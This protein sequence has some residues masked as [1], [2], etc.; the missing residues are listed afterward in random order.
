MINERINPQH[1]AKM[2]VS[3]V[4]ALLLTMSHACDENQNAVNESECSGIVLNEQL[5]Y[6]EILKGVD[7]E[8]LLQRVEQPK[9]RK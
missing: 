2:M 8:F 3:V 7:D 5:G 6:Q 4:I 9:S 1:S